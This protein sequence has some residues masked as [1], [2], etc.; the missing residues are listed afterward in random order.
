M[1]KAYV[2]LEFEDVANIED[3]EEIFDIIPFIVGVFSKKSLAYKAADDL[4][5]QNKDNFYVVEDYA[6]NVTYAKTEEEA[7]QHLS[8]SIEQM[9]KD[10]TIDYKIGED[11]QFYFEVTE[12][13][14]KKIE[15]E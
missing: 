11:G 1:K 5:I 4:A 6:L 12:K 8:R 3:E 14:R 10:G 13:G 2:V 15:D 7:A 9:V